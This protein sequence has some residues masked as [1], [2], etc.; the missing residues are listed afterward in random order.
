[1]YSVSGSV[2]APT[3]NNQYIMC[4]L[5]HKL[6]TFRML[7]YRQHVLCNYHVKLTWGL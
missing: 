6:T 5:K 2:V 7:S 1:M 3:K 4:V